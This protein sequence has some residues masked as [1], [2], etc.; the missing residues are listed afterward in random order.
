MNDIR[1]A[2]A[3]KKT[4]IALAVAAFAVTFGEGL[5]TMSGDWDWDAI[6]K[7]GLTAAFA[8]YKAGVNRMAAE[9]NAP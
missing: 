9:V 5:Q 3:G 8:A 2:L 1:Q 4:Y 6:Y 7:L